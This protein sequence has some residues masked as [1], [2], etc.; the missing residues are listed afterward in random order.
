MKITPCEKYFLLAYDYALRCVFM[1]AKRLQVSVQLQYTPGVVYP[2]EGDPDMYLTPKLVDVF[3]LHLSSCD[4][5]SKSVAFARS[6]YRVLGNDCA[7]TRF[8]H[9]ALICLNCC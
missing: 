4:V 9:V 3:L 8:G 2:R 5:A 6:L 7:P 1:E